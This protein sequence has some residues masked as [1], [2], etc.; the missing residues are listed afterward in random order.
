VLEDDV[1]SLAKLD[2]P[3]RLRP[4]G[5]DLAPQALL[6]GQN[7]AL[8]LIARNAP[9]PVVFDYLARFIE[10][11][12]TDIHC[13][14][15][16]LDGDVLRL[17]AAPTLPDVYNRMIDGVRI[18]PAV[19]SCGTAAYTGQCVV[20]ED[21]TV[22]PRWTPYP[23]VVRVAVS[24]GLRACW[25][26]PIL[27]AN[28]AV[29]GTFAIYYPVPSAPRAA[30]LRLVEIATHVAGI[31]IERDRS[32]RALEDRA[33]RLAEADR[34]KDEFL[35]LLAHELRNPL[36]PIVT[37]LDLMRSAEQ[38][39]GSVARYRGIIERQIRQTVRLIDDLLDVSRITRGQITL[40]RE[41]TSLAAAL[42]CAIESARPLVDARGHTLDVHLPEG[43]PELDAD[44]V[45]L[46]QILANLLN[47][48]AKYTDPGG[49]IAVT[50][51]YEAGEVV[52]CVRDDGMG[53]PAEMLER[54]FDAF[55]QT[56][57]ARARAQGGL[58]IGLTLVKRLVELHGGRISA[59]S[60]GPGRGS[61]FTLRL[62]AARAEL[63]A[64][65]PPARAPGPSP[66]QVL[67]VDDNADAAD[68]L[69]EALRA[70]GHVVRVEHSGVD[71]LADAEA[72]LPDVAIIDIGMPGMDGYEVARRLRAAHPGAPLRLVALTGFGREADQRRAFAAGF[73]AHM[74]KP[75]DLDRIEAALAG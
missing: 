48:A 2:A 11:H 53:I 20:A 73:D 5:G 29:L 37:A 30:D 24:H 3:D 13:S 8:E 25:S 28:G 60:E 50:A 22:D 40:R 51:T 67:V 65:P 31:A 18:G 57:A 44:P 56:E 38:Q 66:R 36:A 26:T 23:D 75:A 1:S 64:P 49:H 61:T 63:A 55:L 46:A 71:A 72:S 19:G 74:V 52:V 27:D 4:G 17:G 54:V 9:L 70:E 12:G 6:E 21:I 15:L 59:A 47:N 32:A 58:G 42:A 41:R 45:R 34:R 62:P 35:A 69:A 14:V 10:A 43:L 68:C 7:R 33:E 39:G 16:V